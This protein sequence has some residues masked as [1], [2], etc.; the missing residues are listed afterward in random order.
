ME[1]CYPSQGL[2][3]GILVMR[4]MCDVIVEGMYCEFSQYTQKESE[5]P[6]S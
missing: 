3:N 2:S 1:M 4:R 6:G 5:K